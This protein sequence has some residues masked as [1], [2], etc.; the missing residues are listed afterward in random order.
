MRSEGGLRFDLSKS[1][2]QIYLLLLLFVVKS[3]A[4]RW[5]KGVWKHRIETIGGACSKALLFFG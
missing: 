3:E 4:K 2:P 1:L 5:V